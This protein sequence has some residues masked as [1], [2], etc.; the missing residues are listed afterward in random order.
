MLPL[1]W[2]P[3]SHGPQNASATALSFSP[4][5]AAARYLLDALIFNF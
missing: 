5:S 4:G 1:Q 2:R 3:L